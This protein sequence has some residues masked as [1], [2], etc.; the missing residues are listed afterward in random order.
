MFKEYPRTFPA[1]RDA[2]F[3]VGRRSPANASDIPTAIEALL[4]QAVSRYPTAS[5]GHGPQSKQCTYGPFLVL[6]K[7]DLGGEDGEGTTADH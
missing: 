1:L 3:A 6:H 4:K 2:F 5:R 7:G